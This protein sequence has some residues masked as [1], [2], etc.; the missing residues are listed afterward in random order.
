M[1]SSSFTR[2][3]GLAG[4]S[5][6]SAS[7]AWGIK[8]GEGGGKKNNAGKEKLILKEGFR[9]CPGV[10]AAP[11]LQLPAGGRAAGMHRAPRA[12]RAERP[13]QRRPRE[14]EN[15]KKLP[16]IPFVPLSGIFRKAGLCLRRSGIPQFPPNPA[17]IWV[18]LEFYPALLTALFFMDLGK[19]SPLSSIFPGLLG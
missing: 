13:R 9:G 16:L 3:D 11:R 6:P 15:F 2:K 18:N 10:R 1:C 14:R 5:I 17:L 19:K 12:V 8:Q 7:D 4:S